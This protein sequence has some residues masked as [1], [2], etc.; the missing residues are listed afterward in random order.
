VNPKAIP[1]EE[2]PNGLYRSTLSGLWCAGK[3]NYERAMREWQ[4]RVELR[5][6]TF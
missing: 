2:M 6:A 4:R 5:K 1:A 3:L